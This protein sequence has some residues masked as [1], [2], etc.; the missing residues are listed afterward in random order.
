MTPITESLVCP[1]S[2]F[3]I[4]DPVITCDGQVYERSA[5]EAWLQGGHET[6]PATTVPL[7]SL[8][9][10][11]LHLL[12]KAVEVYLNAVLG[13]GWAYFYLIDSSE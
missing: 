6:S 7:L 10:L 13:F 9:T 11:S 2:L 12:R 5:I 8:E 3:A 1:I 4:A